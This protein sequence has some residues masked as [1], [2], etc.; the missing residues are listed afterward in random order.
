MLSVVSIFILFLSVSSNVNGKLLSKC[1]LVT[2]LVEVYNATVETAEKFA[3][4]AQYTGFNTQYSEENSFGIF[5]ISSEACGVDEAEGSC[6]LICDS[7]VDDEIEND[8]VCGMTTE[9]VE[10]F[11]DCEISIDDCG[12][13]SLEDRPN[14]AY[15]EPLVFSDPSDELET[16]PNYNYEFDINNVSGEKPIN[17][18]QKNLIQQIVKRDPISNVKYIFLFF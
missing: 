18:E 17:I 9:I 12:L 10:S 3:C 6:S 8:F 2:E 13:K 16:Q 11:G 7:L 5:N 4:I 14:D 15:E 1:E